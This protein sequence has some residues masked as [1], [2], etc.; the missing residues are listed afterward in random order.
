[1]IAED[2]IEQ[3][4]LKYLKRGDLRFLLDF[5]LQDERPRGNALRYLGGMLLLPYLK[6]VLNGP[7]A[8]T[9]GDWS[10]DFAI[11][12]ERRYVGNPSHT[13]R[14]EFSGIQQSIFR[15]AAL[16]VTQRHQPIDKFWQLL[17]EWVAAGLDGAEAKLVFGNY[18]PYRAVV[19]RTTLQKRGRRKGGDCEQN[20]EMLAS[21]TAKFIVE[22]AD[23][24]VAFSL[25]HRELRKVADA[26]NFEFPLPSRNVIKTSYYK[27]KRRPPHSD[28]K[29]FQDQQRHGLEAYRKHLLR[30]VPTRLGTV[31]I[32]T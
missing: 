8:A 9:L 25:V 11:V 17:R 15:N 20:Q 32:S 3:T 4:L 30:S 27:Q 26:E 7:C 1:L 18:I 19:I 5:L 22:V 13:E 14:T 21:L 31:S 6:E 23:P 12:L 28:Q 24:R 29:A 2:A 16:M 10:F